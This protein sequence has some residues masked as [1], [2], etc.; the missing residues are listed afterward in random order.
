MDIITAIN[1]HKR[2]KRKLHYRVSRFNCNVG[3]YDYNTTKL[4]LNVVDTDLFQLFHWSCISVATGP[5]LIGSL[6]DRC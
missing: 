6:R 2:R 3:L 4:G 5:C 1:T